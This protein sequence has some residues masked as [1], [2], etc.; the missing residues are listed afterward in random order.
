MRVRSGPT[1]YSATLLTKDSSVSAFRII[2]G[3][4]MLQNIYKYTNTE[5]R[6]VSVDLNWSVMLHKFD[7]FICLVFAG[8]VG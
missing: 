6:R 2:F 7:K 3:E 1:S 5:Y 4:P 8:V